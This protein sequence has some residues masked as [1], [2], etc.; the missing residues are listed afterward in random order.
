[1]LY[2]AVSSMRISYSSMPERTHRDVFLL[3]IFTFLVGCVIGVG[4]TRLYKPTKEQVLEAQQATTVALATSSLNV[5]PSSTTKAAEFRV[6]EQ[7]DIRFFVHWIWVVSRNASDGR[8]T[9]A[10]TTYAREK[11]I[12]FGEGL[13]NYYGSNGAAEKIPSLFAQYAD[14]AIAYA[15]AVSTSSDDATGSLRSLEMAGDEMVSQLMKVNP[16]LSRDVLQSLLHEYVAGIHDRDYAR[17]AS[18]LGKWVD[19]LVS[20]TVRAFPEQF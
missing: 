12:G 17:M 3:S 20:A 1:M 10:A 5:L 8:D 11:F 4:I 9:V 2:F 6:K 13:Q 7:N 14:A 19:A 15:V 16:G 18:A